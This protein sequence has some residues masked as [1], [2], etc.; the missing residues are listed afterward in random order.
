MA[1]SDLGERGTAT[2]VVDN[3]GDHSLQVAIAFA[4][5]E[6]AEPRRSLAV[7][8]VGLENGARTLT[9]CANYP[10]HSDIPVC[11]C[12][13]RGWKKDRSEARVSALLLIYSGRDAVLCLM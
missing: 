7:V 12:A 13:P 5:I 4:E 8:G 9:L 11:L 1:E 10:S 3:V 6:A 2:G